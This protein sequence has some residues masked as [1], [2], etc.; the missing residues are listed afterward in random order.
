MKMS[1]IQII[2]IMQKRWKKNTLIASK[3]QIL[4]YECLSYCSAGG[5]FARGPFRMEGIHHLCIKAAKLLKS[6]PNEINDRHV[7]C[8]CPG[9]QVDLCL[10]EALSAWSPFTAEKSH[11]SHTS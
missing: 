2:L 10:A 3:F 6:A 5:P 1:L 7:A 4:K 11:P 8:S 9:G